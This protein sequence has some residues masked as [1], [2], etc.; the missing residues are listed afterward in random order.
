MHNTNPADKNADIYPRSQENPSLINKRLIYKKK[1][2]WHWKFND[3]LIQILQSNQDNNNVQ[4]IHLC[5]Y[6]K[7]LFLSRVYGF[8]LFV[9]EINI[10]SI[11]PLKTVFWQFYGHICISNILF[12]FYSNIKIVHASKILHIFEF[13]I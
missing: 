9:T 11:K 10:K 6:K 2:I 4:Y 7:G 8:A 5:M 13:L 1:Q 3:L 12:T